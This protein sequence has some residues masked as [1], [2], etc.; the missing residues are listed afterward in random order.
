VK[1]L[2]E[3]KFAINYS[4]KANEIKHLVKDDLARIDDYLKL[5]LIS[6]NKLTG[7]II[8]HILNSEGKRIR[9]LLS[10]ITAKALN[11]D[12]AEIY[13]LACAVEL[14]HTA[15]LLHDDVIDES[16]KRRGFNTVNNIW[17]NKSAI[18][19]GDFI[20]AKSFELMVKTKNLNVLDNLAR[21]SSVIS[22]GEIAQLELL[23]TKEISLAKYLEVISAKT[24]RLFAEACRNSVVI[25]SGNEVLEKAL[26][27]FGNNLG[28]IFQ[29]IDDM[30]DYFGD[31][32]SLGK[33]I[34]DDFFENKI[35]L[36]IILLAQELKEESVILQEI[37]AKD[38]KQDSDF[39]QV[40][41]LMKKFN[42]KEKSRQFTMSYNELALSCLT[43]LPNSP[44]KALLQDILEVSIYRLN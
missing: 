22:E 18:L 11:Y 25:A 33:S 41:S 28:I 17:D 23:N 38:N 4:K 15:T 14:I 37:L 19:A 24:A 43:V 13:Y 10:V 26:Y 16:D 36:P 42:I 5:N 35:T 1:L 8:T 31:E 30:L 34:G 29:I 39:R 27:D 3:K 21:A 32:K 20:F 40:L 9:P 44:S 6:E 12:K 7:E 2:K